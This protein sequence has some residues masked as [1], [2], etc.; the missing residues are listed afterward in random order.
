MLN[1]LKSDIEEINR[2][3]GWPELYRE[4]TPITLLATLTTNLHGEVSELW[5]AG[6]AGTLGESC[7]KT[8]EDGRPLELTCAQ[9]EIA[10]I[11]IRVL[12]TCHYLGIDVDTSVARKLEF[13]R[14][15]PYRHGGKRA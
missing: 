7:G 1:K 13:N 11:L 8:F 4:L 14:Q 10:D 15:R 2:E 9:E 3:K 5:E 12:D 6:R